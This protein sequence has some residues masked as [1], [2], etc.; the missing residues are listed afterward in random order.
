MIVVLLI[1]IN[2]AGFSQR[3]IKNIDTSVDSIYVNYLD[4]RGFVTYHIFGHVQYKIIPATKKL[5]RKLNLAEVSI[6]FEG[7]K[8]NETKTYKLSK[9]GL[10]RETFINGGFKRNSFYLTYKGK[11]IGEVK[12]IDFKMRDSSFDNALAFIKL[13]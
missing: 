5:K 6:H 8:T 7:H 4:E 12:N 10:F 2:M 3:W 13:K 1:G 11:K 9:E